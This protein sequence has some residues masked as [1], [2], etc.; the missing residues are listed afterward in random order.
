[1]LEFDLIIRLILAVVFG[2]VV[3]WERQ[4]ERK[5]AGLRT[6]MLVSLGSA[7][8]TIISFAI[9]EKFNQSVVDP[10]RIA[11]GIV[12]GVGFLG[13]GAILQSKG[14]IK[15]LTTAASIWIV[16]AIG[17]TCGFGSFLLAGVASIITVIIL[18]L[19]DSLED[20]IASRKHENKN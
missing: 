19:M 13:A 14:E 10:T 18:Y 7:L 11:A 16:A 17:M 3:G 2:G 20:R 1:M 6:H 12:T 5:P 8:F 4:A 15:G 9:L